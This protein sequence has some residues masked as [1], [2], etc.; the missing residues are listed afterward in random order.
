MASI[1]ASSPQS[2]HV[3]VDD[4]QNEGNEEVEEKPDVDHFQVGGVGQAIVHLGHK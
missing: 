4:D 2:F 1:F 3:G